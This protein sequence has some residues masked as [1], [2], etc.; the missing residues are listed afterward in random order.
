[1]PTVAEHKGFRH[2]VRL[3][4]TVGASLVVAVVLLV[5]ALVMI[6]LLRR[7]LTDD[8]RAAADLRA[9]GLVDLL[10]ADVAPRELPLGGDDDEFIQVLSRAGEV[11][12]ASAPVAGER[13]LF[14]G[15][16]D[17]SDV[18]SVPFEDDRFLVVGHATASGPGYTVIV[19]RTLESVDDS[20]GV[21]AGLLGTGLPALLAIVAFVT[22]RVVGR[23]LSPVEV[24]RSEVESISADELHRR[25]QAPATGDE[26]E[27]LAV[28]MNDMLD[29]LESSQQ[30]QRRFV[31]DASHELRSPV[32]S[33]RQ[34]A[35][36]ALKH[37]E[38]IEAEELARAVLQE[39]LRIQ[40]L[41]ED[42]LLLA[43]M[44]EQAAVDERVPLDLD[45]IVFAEIERLV[46]P[47]EIALDT[48]K[49]SGGR[50]RGDARLLGRLV[51][52]LLDNALR[53]ARAKVTVDLREQA[54]E[55]VLSVE[56]DGLGIPPSERE[57]VFERFVRLEEARDRTTGGAG[58]GLAIVD[59]VARAHDGVVRITES[60]GG[61][62]RFEVRLP[63]LSD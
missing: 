48:G 55:V 61:G 6:F 21:V 52:N 49:V 58:L 22:W 37:P 42:L 43:R 26:I 44:G 45:D 59:E 9:Q 19:G 41:V 62:A 27:R 15:D 12:A 30:L 38:R 36:V 28:T 54:E 51:S 34:H 33:I 10:T 5:S 50:L 17:D 7:S 8:V 2:S 53:H 57:R 39:D 56:D 14:D 13:A 47:D 23:A 60:P 3:R 1:M 35:E 40:G 24:L 31:S 4:T 63:R 32:A 11:I 46:V 18:T 16:D 29:R 25:L 20:T